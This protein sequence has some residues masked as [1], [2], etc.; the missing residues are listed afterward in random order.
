MVIQML[1]ERIWV[2]KMCG[3][4][5]IVAIMKKIMKP[6]VLVAAAAMALASCQKNEIPAPE[7]QDV[8]FTI[9]AGIKTRTSIVE[10]A[11]K[12]ESGKPI[13]HA[14]WDGN[15]ELGVLFA[16]PKAETT[17]SDVVRLTNAVSGRTAS[18]QGTVTVD[19][20]AGTFYAFYPAEAFKS[21][22][23]DG[24]ARLDLKNVQKPTATSFDPS[25]DILVAKPYDYEVVDGKVVADGLE[26]ARLMSVL[27]IDLMSEFADIQNEFVESV[28]FTAGDVK[29][30]GYARIF[31]DNPEFNGKWASSGDQWCTVTANYDSD[32]VSI[33]G[34]SNSVYLVIAPVTIPADKDLTFE[35]KTKNY[36]VSKT[37]KSPGMKFTAGKVSKIN[38]TIAADN[39]DK[40]DT[41]IDYS[42]EWLITGVKD[43]QTYAVSAY[44]EGNNLDV[45]VPITVA[46]EKITEVDGL[47]ACKMVITKVSTEGYAGMYTIEDASS[48]E[49]KRSYLYA[50]GTGSNNYLKASSTLSKGSYWDITKNDNGT[51]TII[52]SKHTTD[53][54]TI[55]YNTT[56]NIFSCYQSNS[57]SYKPITLYPYSMVVPDTTP[58]LEL[59]EESIELTAAGGEGTID[60]TAK[61]LPA[62]IQVRALTAKGAQDEVEWLTA[63]Y[64]DGVITYTAEANE[65]E[66]ARTAY[67]E[68]YVSDDLKDGIAVT[69]AGKPAEGDT[70]P[71]FV[72]VTATPADWSGVYILGYT[73][74]STLK[75]LCG[76]NSLG[77]YGAYVD[78]T[79]EDQSILSS[80]VPNECVLTIESTTNGYS[81]NVNN[82]YL[83]YTSTSTSGNNYL[84]FNSS[85]ES[86]KYEWTI[87]M[88]GEN[89]LVTSVYNTN[90]VI[91][92]NNA[93]N[94]LRFACYT[95]SQS[96]I[97]LYKLMGGEPGDE[98]PKPAI[99]VSSEASVNVEAAGATG[100]VSY[101]LTNAVADAKVSAQANQT[102]VTIGTITST[103]V[104]FTVSENIGEQRTAT[105]TLSY[106]G[107]E[108]KTVNITQ[109]EA[110][111]GGGE[112]P[113]PEP[114]PTPDP[115]EPETPVDPN[116]GTPATS[117]C[118]TMET[119]TAGSNNDYTKNCDVTINGVKW[120]VT[121]NAQMTPWRIGGKSISNAD[122]AV[123]TKTAYS[124]ALSKVDF[125]VGT[126]SGS[127]TW[128]S[129]KLIYSTNADFS[130]AQTMTI[131]TGLAASNT[132][133]F[134]PEGGFPENCYFKFVMNVS[135]SGSSN[136]YYQLSSI[137]FYGYDN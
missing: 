66:E 63:A 45:L 38:L 132:Y 123:Y 20:S 124:S 118:Y 22:Y 39:C 116:P 6:F 110:Q 24:D 130:D 76:K 74:G 14:Q 91:K 131:S 121:G 59:G 79:L 94:G 134:A 1:L 15:E 4:S 46:D 29:I 126:S 102:W 71:K 32:L 7:K 108:S 90:R 43:T 48:T 127:I 31:L 34:T 36:T 60:V 3:I 136:K 19:K 17:A 25:C 77:N 65:S 18:F 68:A 23:A 72:K 78:L 54:N 75:T 10:S 56:N 111:S 70:T 98:E 73:D 97:Q 42:G 87:K 69:Q 61:N 27:R 80:E 88:D 115:E 109:A 112:T 53:R 128:H 12:D 47:A 105:I 21:G 81:L 44:V 37:V 100:T 125:Q 84:W 135:V 13:Y 101:T 5:K 129:L 86:S 30:T 85:F 93:S 119:N 106:D 16:A 8:H 82:T 99:T 114:D 64:A 133:S 96:P 9:N 49:E 104:P 107:A 58:K 33:N 51:Y 95:S 92:W 52:A 28:S 2:K 35:I 11:D 67:I 50:A 41:S 117:P 103:S 122:R 26:F 89:V 55:W 57:A 62:D 137:K 40:I 113:E 120:N 83:G